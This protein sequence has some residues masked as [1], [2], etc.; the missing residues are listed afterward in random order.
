VGGLGGGV[1]GR[2]RD[3]GG[4]SGQTAVVAA[5]P[6][7]P[8]R[9]GVGSRAEEL[10]GGEGNLFRGSAGVKVVGKWGTVRPLC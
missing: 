9:E 3:H 8:T 6:R 5:L 1:D 2:R 10:Q 4:S 7:A